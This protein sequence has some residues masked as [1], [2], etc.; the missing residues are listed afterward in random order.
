MSLEQSLAWGKHPQPVKQLP[1]FC[2]A[3][4]FI[5]MFTRAGHYPVFWANL[6][7]STTP[8]P[9][10][11]LRCILLCF[12]RL[13]GFAT[14]PLLPKLCSCLFCLSDRLHPPPIFSV[15]LPPQIYLV[16]LTNHKLLIVQSSPFSCLFLLVPNIFFR[17][18]CSYTL[19][20]RSPTNIR[21]PVS[22]PYETDNMTL[23]CILMLMFR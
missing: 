6:I 5:T 20:L 21:E 13:L 9:S 18:I 14:M 11:P 2:A 23:L 19:N 12:H 7:Q 8:S 4:R 22:H 1:M 17:T 10:V 15:I 3:R 16:R